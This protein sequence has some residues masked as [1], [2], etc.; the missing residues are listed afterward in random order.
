MILRLR[1]P[2]IVLLCVLVLLSSASCADDSRFVVSGELVGNANMNLRYSY[3]TPAGFRS[4]VVAVRDGKFQFSG[5]SA[6]PTLLEM[7]EHDYT[8]LGRLYI[9]NGEEVHVTL[10]RGRPE[11]IKV[12]GSETNGR[13]TDFLNKNSEALRD[14]ARVARVIADYI[15]AHPDD[16]VGT[17]LLVSHYP[18]KSNPLQADS[19]LTSI[20]PQAR[21]EFI[22]GGLAYLIRRVAHEG[23]ERKLDSLC[24]IS[25][26]NRVAS[27]SP[28]GRKATLFFFSEKEAQRPDT[29]LKTLL[30][31]SA[32]Q[33]VAVADI[34]LSA[35]T[36]A[37]RR[38]LRSE[39]LKFE[40]D[41]AVRRGWLPG[42]LGAPQLQNLGIPGLPYV[43]VCD[44][45]GA[46]IYR[47]G[48]IAEAVNTLTHK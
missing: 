43:L 18:V 3:D 26:K 31:L 37:W 28:R 11:D 47:G 40:N 29:L 17:L 24:Y 39:R 4:A 48:E 46:A 45:T 23:A 15:G 44:S 41:G 33:S 38:M 8:P 10:T 1:I 6:Q 21:P 34:Y 25:E 12:S 2:A 30:K 13:W 20:E 35:D 7:F 19:L 36:M 27:L 22:A 5:S 9:A 42:N 16:I 32:R 14:S